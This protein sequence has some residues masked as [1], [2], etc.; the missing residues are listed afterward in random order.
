MNKN[1]KN[2]FDNRTFINSIA[3]VI[4]EK[5]DLDDTT[6]VDEIVS[7]L[8]SS[9]VIQN[10]YDRVSLLS[11]TNPVK[12]KKSY[13]KDMDEAIIDEDVSDVFNTLSLR[14]NY[15]NYV[16]SFVRF[17]T[18]TSELPKVLKDYLESKRPCT[19]T[20][21]GLK[22]KEPENYTSLESKNFEILKHD[23]LMAYN[24][25]IAYLVRENTDDIGII[26]HYTYKY[27][28]L[29]VDEDF[30]FYMKLLYGNKGKQYYILNEKLAGGRFVL[31]PN[32]PSEFYKKSCRASNFTIPDL[33]IAFDSTKKMYSAVDYSVLEPYR[34][35]LTVRSVERDENSLS[36]TT[37]VS[38]YKSDR[39][40]MNVLKKY[41]VFFCQDEEKNEYAILATTT[42]ER[43]TDLFTAATSELEENKKIEWQLS[44]CKK[45]KTLYVSEVK[46][47]TEKFG[48]MIN[49]I[50]SVEDMVEYS[51]NLWL[52]YEQDMK[53]NKYK[54]VINTYFNKMPVYSSG[55]CY[56]DSKQSFI[57]RSVFDKYVLQPRNFYNK[58][59]H[60]TLK[61]VE[62][63][64]TFSELNNHTIEY[65]FSCVLNHLLWYNQLSM[66]TNVLSVFDNDLNVLSAKMQYFKYFLPEDSCKITFVHIKDVYSKLQNIDVDDMDNYVMKGYGYEDIT[67]NMEEL[68]DIYGYA[69]DKAEFNTT[70]GAFIENYLLLENLEKKEV[71]PMYDKELGVEEDV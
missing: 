19:K 35:T 10:K 58:N 4:K 56:F 29:E 1:R 5:A 12:S 42:S 40:L 7:A 32:R 21:N 37:N 16:I 66:N 11:K 59:R 53:T 49:W 67:K 24:V 9:C 13:D 48:Y 27:D 44:N 28:D 38:R 57:V 39:E 60:S 2:I 62:K 20:K 15:K 70:V 61:G 68:V 50:S 33:L 65:L 43:F 36:T 69:D 8:F 52:S 47:Y 31:V 26:M 63:F 45:T 3:D 64:K 30:N 6:V 71:I 18:D 41:S 17:L 46:S 14:K 34:E 23:I 55:K 51:R 22:A 25:L 54:F